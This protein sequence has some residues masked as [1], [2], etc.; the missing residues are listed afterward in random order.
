MNVTYE[1]LRAKGM[2]PHVML[3]FDFTLSQWM[4][5]ALQSHH[6]HAMTDEQVLNLFE[7]PKEEIVGIIDNFQI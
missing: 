5:L 1:Q 4:N 6:V 3:H 2:N 7:M